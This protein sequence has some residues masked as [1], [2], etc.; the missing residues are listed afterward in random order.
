MLAVRS[1]VGS[2]VT[3]RPLPSCLLTSRSCH[4]E[5]TCETEQR[6]GGGGGPPPP[7]GAG[8]HDEGAAARA[9]IRRASAQ[10]QQAVRMAVDGESFVLKGAA[11]TGKTYTIGRIVEAVREKYGGDETAVAV[12]AMTGTAA[13]LIDGV[14]L[15]TWLG[16]GLAEG[17]HKPLV[18]QLMRKHEVALRRAR[19]RPE[20]VE[21]AHDAVTRIRQTRLLIVDECSMLSP[22]FLYKLMCIVRAVRARRDHASGGLQVIACGDFSQLPPVDS[23][24]KRR[25]REDQ[26]ALARAA[27]MHMIAR[28]AGAR[29]LGART[30]GAAADVSTEEIDIDADEMEA[31]LALRRARQDFER[32]RT[33]SEAHVRLR[34]DDPHV[35]GRRLSDGDTERRVKRRR[36][37]YRISDCKYA[38]ETREWNRLFGT[39]FVE[40]REV[41]RQ[42]DP[43]FQRL[44]A[45]ARES[46]LDD[47]DI[48]VLRSRQLAEPGMGAAVGGGGGGAPRLPPLGTFERYRVDALT[49]GGELADVVIEA[50]IGAA[51]LQAAEKTLRSA[52]PTLTSKRQEAQVSNERRLAALAT[53]EHVFARMHAVTE[54]PDFLKAETARDMLLQGDAVPEAVRLR[55]GALVRLTVNTN[56]KN[57]LVNGSTG[58]VVGFVDAA[59][60][61]VRSM[62]NDPWQG[63]FRVARARAA[64]G[65]SCKEEE[66]EEEEG[67]AGGAGAGAGAD[68]LR[69]VA[70]LEQ[71]TREWFDAQPQVPLVYFPRAFRG[72][73]TLVPVRPHMHE[74]NIRFAHVR[75]WVAALPLVL[76]W[77]MTIHSSQ[78]ATL[79]TV[80][81][82]LQRSRFDPK[83]REQL[84]G[85]F[86]PYQAYVQL[87]RARS[88]DG[89]TIG[90]F[91]PDAFYGSP[92]VMCK[93]AE[94]RAIQ[95][96]LEDQEALRAMVEE[97]GDEDEGG[98]PPPARQPAD[99]IADTA[100]WREK[101]SIALDAMCEMARRHAAA[102]P[103]E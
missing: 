72:V 15:H 92:L 27:E 50:S 88:L 58:V 49:P 4:A 14:T 21:A 39:R 24:K 95:A 100:A 3:C 87:S 99:I 81:M 6:G 83:R 80:R 53:R 18:E 10:Q 37:R 86:L 60:L 70:M 66:E 71:A 75:G 85:I 90:Q 94:D 101:P 51:E 26:E 23:A 63:D 16:V 28:G 29:E 34:L 33:I 45:H 56:Q 13:T 103:S 78:G 46:R 74:R 65:K 68:R 89:V 7:R 67:G 25:R 32:T 9:A 97:M 54:S 91:D 84:D 2:S 12:T 55:A 52:V 48:A 31:I 62:M 40:L 96:Y 42:T 8:P 38:F 17:S 20:K 36:V 30:S 41:I 98:G 102:H 47:D 76:S 73:P 43:R 19:G 35:T 22:R 11:G 82:N 1:S 44:L 61:G 93:D 69:F 59:A 57:S 79:D 64:A 5:P 77:A